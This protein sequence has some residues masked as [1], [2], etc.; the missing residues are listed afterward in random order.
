MPSSGARVTMH[1]TK[2]IF[3]MRNLSMSECG[4]L[5]IEHDRDC[6]AGEKM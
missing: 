3:F 1:A 4:R 6:T 2:V 5:W